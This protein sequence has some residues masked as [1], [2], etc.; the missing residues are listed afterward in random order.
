[1]QEWNNFLQQECPSD[2]EPV[3]GIYVGDWLEQ[4]RPSALFAEEP[5]AFSSTHAHP[6]EEPAYLEALDLASFDTLSL[7]SFDAECNGPDRAEFMNACDV[8][9]TG[10]DHCTNPQRAQPS[11]VENGTPGH[12]RPS[13]SDSGCSS[14]ASQSNTS[15]IE[16][17]VDSRCKDT[18][19]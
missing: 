7:D 14:H 1:M 4:G 18:D 16:I 6:H 19:S 2:E 13:V 3:A 8:I 12:S 11:T 9:R 17:R 10:A 15:E 5:S